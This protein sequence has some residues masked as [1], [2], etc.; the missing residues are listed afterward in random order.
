VQMALRG[1]TGRKVWCKVRADNVPSIHV[2][3]ACGFEHKE[4][5]GSMVY[6]ELK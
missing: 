3:L 4:I 2:A 1:L 5:K 6:M